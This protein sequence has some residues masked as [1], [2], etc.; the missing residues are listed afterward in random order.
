MLV[1][2]NAIDATEEFV[3]DERFASAESIEPETDPKQKPE[4]EPEQLPKE[5]PGQAD[6][7]TEEDDDDDEDPFTETEIGDDPDEIEK[8][9]TIF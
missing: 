2:N 1:E 6:P 8:K 9:T 7:D 5:D 3:A 4:V